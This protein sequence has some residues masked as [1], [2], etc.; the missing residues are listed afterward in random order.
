MPPPSS[1]AALAVLPETPLA[2]TRHFHFQPLCSSQA[3]VAAAV[4]VVAEDAGNTLA[5]LGVVAGLRVGLVWGREGRS[6]ELVRAMLWG[7]V[8]VAAVVVAAAAV[9]AVAAAAV[10]VV[11]KLEVVECAVWVAIAEAVAGDVGELAGCT[12]L[13]M[14]GLQLA[15]FVVVVGEFVKW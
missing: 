1:L 9:L 15:G 5:R 7:V 6:E 12:F 8:A 4:V 2:R 13:G 11:D 10:V 14:R 3:I